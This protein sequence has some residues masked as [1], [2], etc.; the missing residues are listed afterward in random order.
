VF[1]VGALAVALGAARENPGR[2]LTVDL[3][4]LGS[5]FRRFQR[6]HPRGVVA[7]HLAHL[8]P[9]SYAIVLRCHPRELTRRLR[10]AHRPVGQIQANV[11]SEVLDT[12]LVEALSQEVPVREIDTTG[13]SPASVAQEVERI[14]RRRPPARFG[15]VDWLADRW[16][17]EQLLRDPR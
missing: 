3:K 6:D 10:G 8:L 13:R 5:A 15:Q 17:T 7:G 4:K 1:E 16:V 9:V 14:A 2:V 11:L 12:V